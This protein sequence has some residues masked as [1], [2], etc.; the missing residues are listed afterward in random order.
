MPSY[1]GTFT[2][3]AQ[4]QAI[5][6]GTW[7]GLPI[8]IGS[9]YEG[10]FYAGQISTAGNG[11]ADYY[12]IVGPV[13]SAQS[14]KQ[15]KNVNSTS[16]GTTSVTDGPQNTAWMVADGSSTV[17]PAAHFCNNLSIGGYT[18]WYMPAR[19]EL[20]ICYYNLKPTTDSNN[21]GY[22]AN[23]NAVPSRG[24]NHTAG[25]P[26]QTSASAFQSGGA[27]A[28]ASTTS[29]YWASTEQV[30]SAGWFTYFLNGFQLGYPK[31]SSRRVRAIR[32]VAV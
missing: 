16:T 12:I 29:A 21:T 7:T 6:A 30:D 27:E 19:D 31:N 3:P 1:S 23:T 15:W 24:S 17:Y 2:L 32:R 8:P 14:T 20:E 25:D 10:G 28:F 18:D 11:V 9:A 26:A 22:G 13:A 5:A 4:M